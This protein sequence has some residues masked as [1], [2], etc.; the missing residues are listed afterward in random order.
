MI[1]TLK[2]GVFSALA[3]LGDS[4]H[5]RAF[6]SIIVSAAAWGLGTVYEV[7][8]VDLMVEVVAGMTL[9]AWSSRTPKLESVDDNSDAGA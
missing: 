3:W 4:A 9:A 6:A 2:S 7:E 1:S 5:R 8:H